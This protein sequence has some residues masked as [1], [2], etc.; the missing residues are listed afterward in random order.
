MHKN[1][2]RYLYSARLLIGSLWAKSKVMTLSENRSHNFFISKG[3][4]QQI[5]K[6]I[7]LLTMC[8]QDS[9]LIRHR[10]IV[11]IKSIA[12]VHFPNRESKILL[13][14]DAKLTKTIVNLLIVKKVIQ[15][16]G[17][18]ILLTNYCYR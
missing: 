2:Y 5:L 9:N 14:F 18:L 17:F 13:K 16:S 8:H 11:F 4:M 12:L 6:L 15:L 10:G 7:V 1:Q 3:E